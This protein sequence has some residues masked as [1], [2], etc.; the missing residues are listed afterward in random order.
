M[1]KSEKAI[2]AILVA[3]LCGWFWFTKKQQAE[4]EKAYAQYLAEH[5][6]L[7]AQAEG[8]DSEASGQNDGAGAAAQGSDGVAA[9]QKSAGLSA[10]DGTVDNAAPTPP[11]VPERTLE[12]GNNDLR[13]VFTSRGGAVKSA[14]LPGYPRT[15]DENSP[16]VSFDFSSSPALSLEGVSGLGAADGDFSLSEIAPEKLP[17]GAAGGVE[18]RCRTAS[19]LSLVRRATWAS[20]GFAVKVEDTFVNEGAAPVGIDAMA[21]ALGPVSSV[22]AADLDRDLGV[23]A[24]IERPDG[25]RETPQQSLSAA[26]FKGGP[27]FASAFGAA[28]GGCQAATLPPGA[29]VSAQTRLDGR[30]DWVAVRER[31]FVEVLTPGTAGVSLETRIERAADS[32]TGAPISLSSVGGA[33]GFASSQLAPGQ[34]LARSYSLYLGP[35][36][37]SELRKE[38]AG[39]LA[40]MRFGTWSWFCRY[41]LD[42]LNFIHRFV[43]NYGWAI[44]VLTLVVR[45]V[46]LPISRKSARSM[47]KMAEIQ[48]QIK[49]LQE[50]YKDDPRKLQQEQMRLYSENHVNPLSGCLPMLLQLPVFV[51]LFTVLRSAVELRYAPWLWIADLS[52]PENCFRETIGFGVNFLPIAMAVTMTL[53]SR[54]TP[55]AGDAQQQKMMTVMMPVMML[56]MCYNFASALGL[57]WSVSQALAIAGMLWA[58]RGAGKTGGDSGQP[59]VTVEPP[60]RETRQMRRE[61]ERRGA[62]GV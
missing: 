1:N 45:L 12:A 61:R 53:Q 27:T 49:A 47:R 9:G 32:Q 44:V 14:T 52:E 5:P 50:K 17:Q 48:P 29:P 24:S 51:A 46:M 36:K 54:L 6:E 56:V 23:D 4:Y 21:V 2:V 15:L 7:A 26:F 16:P 30:I 38:G 42:L 33:L 58:R 18:A 22:S 37:M 41:L 19:G 57:Y 55:S 31:F 25:K 35:K 43:P 3:L 62:A 60:G 20:Q 34:S 10:W 11:A 13:I 40:I 8:G 59:G 28:G 39:H